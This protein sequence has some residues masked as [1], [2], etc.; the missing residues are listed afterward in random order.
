MNADV[1]TALFRDTRSKLE[2]SPCLTMSARGR[3]CP[4]FSLPLGKDAYASITRIALYT[5]QRLIILDCY[6]PQKS[7]L[8]D[9]LNVVLGPDN[10]K[11][12]S[13]PQH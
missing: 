6:V 3:P 12:S 4:L 10:V 13:I 2:Q 5:L 11:L 8:P 9:H 1:Q 7:R